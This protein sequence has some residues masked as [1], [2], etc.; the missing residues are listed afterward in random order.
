MT[1]FKLLSAGLIAATMF[2]APAMARESGH[3]T[4]RHV[5]A[6]AYAAAPDATY[7]AGCIRAP[8][9]GAFASDPWVNPPCEPYAAY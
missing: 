8:R 6:R 9:E 2:A 5:A 3:E 4:S 7:A 1:T